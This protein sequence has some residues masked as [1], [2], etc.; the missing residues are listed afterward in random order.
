MQQETK[1]LTAE[2]L[3]ERLRVKPGTVRVWS[4]RGL[5]P[6]QRLSPKVIRYDLAAVVAALRQRAQQQTGGTPHA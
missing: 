6:R 4:R 1:M 3:A 2:E 5:I